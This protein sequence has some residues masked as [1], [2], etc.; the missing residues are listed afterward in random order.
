MWADRTSTG[1]PPQALP[2]THRS[3]ELESQFLAENARTTDYIA[4]LTLCIVPVP[5]PRAF[6]VL[7]MP[8]PV[9]SCALMRSTTSWLTGRRP[10]CFPWLRARER[11]A[12]AISAVSRSPALN[13]QPEPGEQE[14]AKLDSGRRV[15]ETSDQLALMVDNAGLRAR[16]R[17]C[18]CCVID[19]ASTQA[20]RCTTRSKLLR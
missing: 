16:I 5:T 13:P 12:S 8:A 6:A 11:P 14:L 9:A 3:I 2:A 15:A 18:S 19:F 4:R 17:N 10:S 7:R 20:S 1:E